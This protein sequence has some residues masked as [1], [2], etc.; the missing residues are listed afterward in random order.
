MEFFKPGRVFDFMGQRLFW[1]PLSFILVGISIVLCFFPGPNYGTD[2]RGGTEIEMAFGTPID[3]AGVRKAVEQAGFT[4]P[5]VV[6]VV[7]PNKPYHFLIRVQ[8]VSAI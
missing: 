7:D 1:I 5:D 8:D 2:F 3:A 4:S 6:Q